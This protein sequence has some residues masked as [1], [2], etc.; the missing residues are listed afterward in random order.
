MGWT[1]SHKPQNQKTVEYFKTNW[2]YET[3]DMTHEVIDGSIVHFNQG[4]FACKVTK[5]ETGETYVYC[6]TAKLQFRD[7]YYNLGYKD[8]CEGDG[9]YLY[10]C[11]ARIVKKLTPIPEHFQHS[12]AEN[13]RLSQ[14]CVK[15]GKV[16]VAI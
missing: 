7:D 5:K 10:K 15:S 3:D 16:K 9:P 13:W 8:M 1:F 2:S 14:E 11:P 6:I 4:Y 12:Y